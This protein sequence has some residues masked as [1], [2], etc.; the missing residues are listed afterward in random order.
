MKNIL[1]FIGIVFF[2]LSCSE[3]NII[4]GLDVIENRYSYI[5]YDSTGVKIVQGW[6]EIN[7]ADSVRVVGN[8]KLSK[9]ENPQNIGPQTGTGELSG[10]VEK[11]QIFIDL[12]PDYRDNNVLL[13]ADFT[14]DK[15][16][17]QWN[18]VGFPGVMNYGSF[19][20]TKK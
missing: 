11:E 4:A 19:K 5:G 14:R 20:A 15:I 8:W 6:I 12:N 1:Y 2:T 18:Y 3:K 9:I 13:H 17:G 7:F 16:E 10:I